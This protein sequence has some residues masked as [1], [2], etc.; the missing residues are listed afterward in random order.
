MAKENL[1]ACLAVTL[2]HEGGWS[3]HPKDPG[4]ATMKGITLTTYRRF[5]PNATKTDLRNITDDEVRSIYRVDYWNKV[6]GED[7]PAGIDLVTFDYGVNSGPSR[8]V[9][10]LQRQVGAKVDGV[11]GSETVSKANAAEGKAVIQGVSARRMSFLQGLTTW[12]TFKR[13]WSKRVADVEA[14]AVAMW[15]A[16]EGVSPAVASGL[17]AVEA[18]RA[19][20]TAGAQKKSAATA[21]GGS[22][23][24]GGGDT[25]VNGDPNWI[26]LVIAATI[27]LGAV[28][29]YLKSRHNSER[30]AAYNA[31]AATA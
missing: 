29:L 27:V 4:G 9:K 26:I 19:G 16:A 1:P 3:D 20:D 7:L 18:G 5:K 30:A 6:R 31:V 23:V 28:V 12:A 22:A 8:A 17:L 15:L 21:A 2:E 25:V 10:D 14:K 11:A 24:V 13:G